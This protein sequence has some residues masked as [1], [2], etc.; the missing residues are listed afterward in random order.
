[1]TDVPQWPRKYTY[2]S[3]R[4]VR[5][6]DAERWVMAM[7]LESR[8]WLRQICCSSRRGVPI[9][10]MPVAVR[11]ELRQY[12]KIVEPEQQRARPNDWGRRLYRA[13]L[14]YQSQICGGDGREHDD[15]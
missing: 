2:A 12:I 1:M 5:D 8:I 13:W 15:T 7:R 11:D 14:D 4:D 6:P 9:A 3:D 10:D